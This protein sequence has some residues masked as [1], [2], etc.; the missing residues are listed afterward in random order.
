M[1]RAERLLQLLQAL[2]RHRHPVS[3][4]QLASEIEV[5][6]RS[7]YRDIQSLRSQGAAIDGEAGIGY[8]LRPGFTLPPLSLDENEIDALV[9]GARWVM[10]QSDATLSQGARNVIAKISAV[11]PVDQQDRP[12]ATALLAGPSTIASVT[13]V[14]LTEIRQ[15]IRAE[16][17]VEL[18]YR[19]LK[20]QDSR[21]IVWP[22]ALS[23]FDRALVL[24]AWCELRQDFRHFRLDQVAG[25]TVTEQRYPERRASL[26]KRWHATQQIPEQY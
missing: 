15:A 13:A 1:S 14:D 16:R 11:L 21:R 24:V 5:S 26:L 4:A 8:V 9:L 6:V 19:D 12:A 25:L 7:V 3:A 17:R 2:R 22:I 20:G 18:A 23:F 10:Q